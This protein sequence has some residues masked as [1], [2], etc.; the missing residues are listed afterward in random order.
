MPE[1]TII[2]IGLGK[3][4][5]TFL[6]RGV[7][8]YLHERKLLHNDTTV[9][10]KLSTAYYKYK[11]DA[12]SSYHIEEKELSFTENPIRFISAENI[13]GWNPKDFTKA[14]EAAKRYLPEGSEILITMREPRQWLRSLYL[15]SISRCSICMRPEHF[16]LK[17]E[18]MRKHEKFFG[19]MSENTS[20][21]V[22][23]LR[24]SNIEK[25]WKGNFQT[26]HILPMESIINM[27][28]LK[29]LQ[30]PHTEKHLNTL[31]T[32]KS[33]KANKS[34]NKETLEL[35][36]IRNKILKRDFSYPS[37]TYSM[38]SAEEQFFSTEY[39]YRPVDPTPAEV[40]YF[41]R[42]LCRLLEK[43][44]FSM[45][46]DE[47]FSHIT[48]N[49]RKLMQKGEELLKTNTKYELPDDLYL[50]KYYKENKVYYDQLKNN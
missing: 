5:S 3:T 47:Y 22:D 19:E 26:V 11:I 40:D 50:G 30:I 35:T 24:Y 48:Q 43:R 41:N 8:P 9:L 44:S 16:F 13:I 46:R 21:S 34:F 18:Q 2:H 25:E 15:H 36:I 33:T 37:N 28:F 17:K 27:E 39:G 45:S 20:I 10:Q 1:R 32:I 38:L 12:E 31:S 42:S 6:Q 29:K 49:W 7:L 14:S 4:G 23:D